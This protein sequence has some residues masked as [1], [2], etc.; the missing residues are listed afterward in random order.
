MTLQNINV[1]RLLL[2]YLNLYI[3][4]HADDHHPTMEANDENT[5]DDAAA[6]NSVDADG[7]RKRDVGDGVVDRNDWHWN[8]AV[9]VA[10]ELNDVPIKCLNDDGEVFDVD[11]DVRGR[12]KLRCHLMKMSS[13]LSYL[14]PVKVFQN[15]ILCYRLVENWGAL[16]AWMMKPGSIDMVDFLVAVRGYVD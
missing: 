10:Y 3:V 16:A 15:T 8:V 1:L 9:L 12:H 7:P 14:N 13:L 6:G 2:N 11:G 5:V 4:I